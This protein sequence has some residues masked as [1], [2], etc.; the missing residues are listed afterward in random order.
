MER[1][2]V[3][4]RKILIDDLEILLELMLQRPPMLMIDK[5]LESD[6]KITKTNFF[7]RETCIFSHEDVLTEPGLIEN[8]AQTGAVRIGY[9]ASMQNKKIP[10]GFIGAITNL[11]IYFLPAVNTELEST[12]FI[13]YNIYNASIIKAKVENEGRIA[14]ECEMKIFIS[15]D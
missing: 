5:L 12:I 6:D 4:I 10:L 9:H 7:I 8:I 3:G 15:E 11:N 2:S 13:E 1:A 14:C